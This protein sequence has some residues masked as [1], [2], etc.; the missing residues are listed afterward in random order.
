MTLS[1][2]RE[3]KPEILRGPVAAQILLLFPEAEEQKTVCS[4][5]DFISGRVDDADMEVW[6]LNFYYT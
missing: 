3:V 5:I 4:S 6:N 1:A 2:L